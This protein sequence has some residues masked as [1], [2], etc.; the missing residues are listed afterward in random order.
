[1]LLILKS[2]S[3]RK[4]IRGMHD[5]SLPSMILKELLTELCYQGMALIHC[6]S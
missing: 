4:D 2:G 6:I 5:L 1:M 3:V